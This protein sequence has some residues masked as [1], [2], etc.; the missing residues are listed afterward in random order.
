[1]RSTLS[2]FVVVVVVVFK[3]YFHIPNGGKLKQG[4]KFRVFRISCSRA[5]F[6]EVRTAKF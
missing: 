2:Q 1:M 3:K 5:D 6:T 4:A